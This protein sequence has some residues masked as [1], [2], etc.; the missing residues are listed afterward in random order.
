M[1]TQNKESKTGKSLRE[2]QVRFFWTSLLTNLFRVPA[3][4]IVI[5]LPFFIDRLLGHLAGAV[6]AAASVVVWLLIGL[7]LRMTV[8]T[9][10]VVWLIPFLFVILVAIV[11]IAL[12]FHWKL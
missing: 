7:R 9:R 12:F 4:I 2:M 11:E 3:L 6:A 5:F 8:A 1:N 10:V